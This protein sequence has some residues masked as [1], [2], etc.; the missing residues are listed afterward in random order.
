MHQ[1]IPS[2]PNYFATEKG[3]IVRDG[4]KLNMT[5]NNNGYLRVFPCIN[6][7]VSTR[8]VHQLVL[9]AFHG[10]RPRDD[11]Q[12]RHLNGNRIDNRPENLAWSDKATNEAD[13]EL[14]GTKLF[15]ERASWAVLT[16]AIVMEARTRVASGELIQDVAD[17]LMVNRL[18][19]GEAVCGKKWAHLPGAVE[20]YSTR[21]KF[22]PA[23]IR[24]IRTRANDQTQMSLAREYGVN[25]EAIRQI[26]RRISYAN[27]E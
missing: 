18:T 17:D 13:K 12:S 4:K 24:D 25:K 10:P 22:S 11:W 16:D 26:I 6:G 23:Q 14:H 7:R 19:L 2:C 5:P 8:Y 1:P 20:P 15:G 21:R 27:V 3:Y 9:E